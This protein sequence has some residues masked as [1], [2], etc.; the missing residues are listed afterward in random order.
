MQN[1][2]ESIQKHITHKD[3]NI[4]P[5]IA[6]GVT[7]EAFSFQ[8]PSKAKMIVTNFANYI[9]V[10]AAWG[11][12]RWVLKRNGVGI[13]PYN[14]IE[15][16]IAFG[17]PLRELAGVEIQGGDVFSIDIINSYT[18]TVKCGIALKYQIQQEF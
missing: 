2:R 15:D 6:S 4:S 12:I 14:E 7:V 13:F 1:I 5:V 11:D 18:A 10:F 9:N 8:V 17:A 16:Q 3:I